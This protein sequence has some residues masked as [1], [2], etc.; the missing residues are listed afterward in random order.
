M[1][2]LH[3][4]RMVTVLEPALPIRTLWIVSTDNRDFTFDD[5]LMVNSFSYSY[6]F[7]Q[8]FYVGVMSKSEFEEKYS[9]KISANWLVERCE[10][11]K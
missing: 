7:G 11:Q 9:N 1:K 2:H 6:E 8:S 10:Q 3:A 5:I 4:V